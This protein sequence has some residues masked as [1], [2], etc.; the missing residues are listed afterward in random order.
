MKFI[1]KTLLIAVFGYIAGIYYPFWSLA[2]VAFVMSLIVR[3]STWLGFLA[4]FIAIFIL[5]TTHAVVIDQATQA[6]LT[7]RVATV[8]SVSNPVLI[9]LT[10]IIGGIVSGLGAASGSAFTNMFRRKRQNRYY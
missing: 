5:W 2:I 7:T 4:G 10:G 6:L 8:F 9:L 1:I 3:T